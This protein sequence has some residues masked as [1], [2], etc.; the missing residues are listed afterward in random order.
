MMKK[1]EKIISEIERFEKAL[2][3]KGKKIASLLK[4]EGRIRVVECHS[5]G[6]DRAL[7]SGEYM[8]ITKKPISPQKEVHIKANR[9]KTDLLVDRVPIPGDEWFYARNYMDIA[10]GAYY[11]PEIFFPK[12]K[13]KE[14][15]K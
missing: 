3:K 8:V 15:F 9:F 12:A 10:L 11:E 7:P 5:T 1:I 13:T 6:D 14:V 4:K 2:E